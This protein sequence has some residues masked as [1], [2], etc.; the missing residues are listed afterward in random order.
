ML[1]RMLERIRT[2]VGTRVVPRHGAIRGLLRAL[3]DR[4]SVGVMIDQHIQDRSAVMVD[5]FQPSRGHDVGHRGTGPSHRSAGDSGLRAPVARGTVPHGF[6]K[7]RSSRRPTTIRTR[8]EPIPSGARM[9]SRC[10]SA[11][12]RSSGSGCI[13]AGVR[14]RR[15][16][17]TRRAL[18]PRKG[19]RRPRRTPSDAARVDSSRS[20]RRGVGSASAG[21][22]R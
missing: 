19:C 6:T 5:Y 14:P 3:L 18:H 11:G 4:G 22:R 8:S 12:T 15:P 17:T 2:R 1:D 16:P 9:F 10:T 21:P 7:P 13:D 20:G